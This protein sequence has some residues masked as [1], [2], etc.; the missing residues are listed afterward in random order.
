M[1]GIALPTNK[2]NR[3]HAVNS[4]S[5]DQMATHVRNPA[6]ERKNKDLSYGLDHLSGACSVLKAIRIGT[7]AHLDPSGCLA[8]RLLLDRAG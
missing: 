1:D 6:E 8:V 7:G 2:R 4:E 5:P 3:N